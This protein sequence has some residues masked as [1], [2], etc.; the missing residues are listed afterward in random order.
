MRRSVS[1]LLTFA[2]A[3]LALACGAGASRGGAKVAA[4]ESGA[5]IVATVGGESV[6][7]AELEASAPTRLFGLRTQEFEMREQLA[8]ELISERLFQQEAT[9]R[10]LSVEALLAAEVDAKVAPVTETEVGAQYETIKD[11]VKDRPKEQVLRNIEA[12]MKR[13]RIDARRAAYVSELFTKANVR[14]ALQPPRIQLPVANEPALGPATAPV[15][16]IEFSD[17]QCPYCARAAATLKQLRGRYGEKVR[18]VFRDMPLVSIH[19]K[20]A[21]AA[22][23]AACAGD[24]GKFW[25]MSDSLFEHQQDLD[26][27]GLKRRAGEVGL[28]AAAFAA[29]LDSGRKAEEVQKDAAAA[30]ELGLSGTPAFFINGRLV[31]GALS[32]ER[33]AEIVDAEIERASAPPAK[34]RK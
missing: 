32:L 15:T 7:R 30:E 23:A 13:Q 1:N 17:Y 33:F 25:E 3:G 8:R 28:D 16:I 18:L 31:R 12:G 24:Q 4:A 6:S 27:D 19:P 9:A 14:L 22:E 21:K 10:K 34:T 11:R 5:E 29:C 26:P 20:A 2:I